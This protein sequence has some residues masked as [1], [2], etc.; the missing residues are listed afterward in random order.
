MA[1]RH[2]FLGWNAPSLGWPI[3][4]GI[5]MM[6]L[7]AALIVGWVLFPLLP[8]ERSPALYYTLLTLGI[9]FLV[10]ILLG[11][12]FYLALTIKAIALNQRQ[13]NFIDSVTHE[14]KS[15]V[16][17][18]KLYLQTL[19]RHDVSEVQRR[20]FYEV[21]LEDI[22]RLDR[23]ITQ[24]LDAARV[25]RSLAADDLEEINLAELLPECVQAVLPRHCLEQDIVSYDLDAV[26]VR[27]QRVDLEVVFRNLIDNAAKYA[28][29]PPQILLGCHRR[30]NKAVIHVVDNGRG[31][32]QQHRR[33]IFGRFIRLGRELERDKPGTGL[34]LYLVK[35]LLNRLGGRISV[36]A[37]EHSPGTVFEVLLPAEAYWQ[38][39]GLP[40]EGSSFSLTPAT[41]EDTETPSSQAAGP[42]H[43]PAGDE[44]SAG[45]D[46]QSQRKA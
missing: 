23:L 32:S 30:G 46:P 22:E 4:L 6:L 17:S 18:L 37:R 29:N 31:I 20:E 3:T 33:K 41:P 16:A 21:M 26:V 34:G 36:R 12:V 19:N 42:L 11:V 25:D 9:L 15:P 40:K 5:I 1:H 28:G 43:H 39:A 10:L 2:S 44:M 14:L 24:L 13:S 38:R 8:A 7:V 27:G 45:G 35:A